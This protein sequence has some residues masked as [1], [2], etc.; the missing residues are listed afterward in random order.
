MGNF[1]GETMLGLQIVNAQL[2]EPEREYR[3]DE[4]RRWRFDFAYPEHKVAIEVEGGV[5]Q[6]GRHTRGKGFTADCEKYNRATELGWAVF[7]YPTAQVKN[8]EAIKQLR[9][10][11]AFKMGMANKT[12]KTMDEGL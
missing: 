10:I 9:R 7:R 4:E 6:Q 8:G 12:L 11:L 2:G 5:F 3:F 1:S